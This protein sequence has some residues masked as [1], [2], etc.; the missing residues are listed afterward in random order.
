R[1]FPERRGARGPRWRLDAPPRRSCSTSSEIAPAGIWKHLSRSRLTSI[2]ELHQGN[3]PAANHLSG[4]DRTPAELISRGGWH[5]RNS[6]GGEPGSEACCGPLLRSLRMALTDNPDT[7]ITCL[8]PL[9]TRR[10]Q[11]IPGSTTRCGKKVTLQEKR[12]SPC[13][14][15]CRDSAVIHRQE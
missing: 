2:L 8:H 14:G 6:S 11:A 1:I 3:N 12:T 9:M 4:P 15:S 13:F 10:P 7:S 5:T